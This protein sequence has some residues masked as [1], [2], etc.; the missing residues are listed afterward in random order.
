LLLSWLIVI[1]EEDADLKEAS[2]FEALIFAHSVASKTPGLYYKI[3]PDRFGVD[4]E[5]IEWVT[6]Q[7]EDD[8]RDM[9]Q[10]LRETGYNVQAE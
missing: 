7:G 1:D 9:L 8:V 3:W 5:E 6:P 4:E 10:A 2:D